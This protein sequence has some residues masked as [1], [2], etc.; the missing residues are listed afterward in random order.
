M[1]SWGDKLCLCSSL[2]LSSHPSQPL[3]DMR[4]LTDLGPSM[5]LEKAR[6]SREASLGEHCMI[7]D[8]MIPA[9]CNPR[10]GATVGRRFAAGMEQ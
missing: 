8:P 3:P 7:P 1:S 6:G 5:A 9:T 4:L 2:V 10:V